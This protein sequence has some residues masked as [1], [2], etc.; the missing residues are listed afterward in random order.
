MSRPDA[1]QLARLGRIDPAL[2]NPI[3]HRGQ[4]AQ[5]D[6][7]LI[8]SRDSLVRT[9]T[10]L[11]NHVR[12]AVKAHG[13]R[14][15]RCSAPAF[16]RKAADAIP[17]ELRLALLPHLELIAHLSREIT[18]ADRAVEQLIAER[19]P[20]A[21]ALRQVPGV[22]PLTAL[23]FVL[24]LEDPARFRRSRQV[25]AYLGLT[26][27]QRQSG[28]RSQQLGIAKAGDRHLRRL[29]VSCA[30]YILGPFGPDSDLRRWGLR[31]A[32]RGRAARSSVRSSPR[33]ASW[34][35]GSCGS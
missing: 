10:A 13:G 30:H 21:R 31:Y 29:L 20:D 19:Y 28:E 3:R 12:G 7:A 26:P 11:I 4:Q 34:D 2:L 5:Q 22:G 25:A 27:R 16:P 24:T 9:R 18:A 33:R 6:L 32:P 23:T 17:E 15:P 1:E 35:A 14:L 8:R